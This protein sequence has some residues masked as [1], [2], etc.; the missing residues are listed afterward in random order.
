MRKFDKENSW[1]ECANFVKGNTWN[2]MIQIKIIMLPFPL[3]QLYHLQNFPQI[4]DGVSLT[5]HS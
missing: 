1:N 4:Y 5:F 2:E 3:L